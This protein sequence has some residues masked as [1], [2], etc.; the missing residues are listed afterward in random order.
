MVLVTLISVNM[1]R[2]VEGEMILK[3]TEWRETE[4][5][6]VIALTKS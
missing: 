4:S 5:R 1:M 2:R 3:M 6:H